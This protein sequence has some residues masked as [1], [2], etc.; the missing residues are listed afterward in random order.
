M[1]HRH[2]MAVCVVCLL[3]AD[4][5]PCRLHVLAKDTND[6]NIFSSDLER[7]KE[8]Q[9][10]PSANEFISLENDLYD[11]RKDKHRQKRHVG[12]HHE[13]H[14][15]HEHEV[16][17]EMPEVTKNHIQRLF[18][19]YNGDGS[20]LSV[21]GFER[22]MQN[23]RL[24]NLF[25]EQKSETCVNQNE[26]LEKMSHNHEHEHEHE[27]EEEEDHHDHNHS[28][29]KISKDNMLSICP[30]LLY[31]ASV[32]NSTCLESSNFN[33]SIKPTNADNLV[34]MEDRGVVWLYSTLAIFLV[35]LC[36]LF[37]I[38]VIPIMD[39]H[40][41]HH[42]LQFLVAL[43]VGTLAGDALLHL[44]PH[45]MMKLHEGQDMHQTM[46]SRGLAAM[47]AIV[48]FYFF[49]RF[50]VMITEWRQRKEKRDKPSSRVRV[51][52]DQETLTLNGAA[53]T[54]KHKYSSYPYCYDEITTETKD[55]HHEH[56]HIVEDSSAPNQQLITTQNETKKING[57]INDPS[58]DIDNTTLTLSTSLDDGSIESNA[59]CNNNKLQTIGNS[60]SLINSTAK[61]NHE[62][63]Q[64][65]NY[66]IILR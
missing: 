33:L 24:K 4:H 2:L 19:F 25:N 63:I 64:E 10:I 54:C 23:L 66:T 47:I 35:S 49:E 36:G 14:H 51:M 34:E 6:V 3:C 45:A 31:F 59:L 62:S 13:T 55:D 43:A 5:L 12:G 44:M 58:N 29:I 7:A 26:F 38:A 57:M 48:F 39:M 32:P 16:I 40:I 11:R 60:V 17:E 27:E 9:G 15:H 50:L 22:M 18:D 42:A 8:M 37:G 52:R 30:I 53:P 28:D 65:E 20:S 1:A 61:N 46:M 41:Y 56:Q 21:A